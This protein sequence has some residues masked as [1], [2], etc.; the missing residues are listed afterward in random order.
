MHS[1]AS[2]LCWSCHPASSHAPPRPPTNSHTM[3]QEE[4]EKNG[5]LPGWLLVDVDDGRCRETER[6]RGKAQGESSISARVNLSDRVKLLS[7]VQLKQLDTGST[8]S[9]IQLV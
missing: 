2:L 3:L 7:L 9:Q 4:E 8:P 5:F 1:Q 6:E